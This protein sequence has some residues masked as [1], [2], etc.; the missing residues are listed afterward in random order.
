MI[1]SAFIS[2]PCT[3][4]WVFQFS[5]RGCSSHSGHDRAPLGSAGFQ[6]A[7]HRL[8]EQVGTESLQSGPVWPGGESGGLWGRDRSCGGGLCVWCLVGW[9]VPGGPQQHTVS[10][11]GSQAA[12][13]WCGRLM[14]AIIN[15]RMSSVLS[16][17]HC[18]LLFPSCFQTDSPSEPQN[19][20]TREPPSFLFPNPLAL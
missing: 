2:P 8:G 17:F 5:C 11:P 18:S 20:C 4:P 9:Q 19:A 13:M 3:D 15:Q 14:A 1:I 12:E 16:F 7:S 6:P 10:V